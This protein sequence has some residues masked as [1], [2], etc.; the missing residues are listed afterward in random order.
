M[1]TN[2][3]IFYVQVEKSM[4]TAAVESY[5]NKVKEIATPLFDQFNIAVIFVPDFNATRFEKI[6]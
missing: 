2:L 5:V 6:V 4:P 3:G 1:K